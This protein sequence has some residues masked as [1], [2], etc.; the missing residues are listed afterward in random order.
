M[1]ASA[2]GPGELDAN[3]KI[4]KIGGGE[5]VIPSSG[6]YGYGGKAKIDKGV[7]YVLYNGKDMKTHGEH[8]TDLFQF[9]YKLKP[10]IRYKLN[11]PIYDFEIDWRTK[12]LYGLRM[13][14]S[15]SQLVIFQL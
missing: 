14:G 10:T 9:T 4:Q 5:R 2:I 8:V 7:I 13:E 11:I 12:R 1:I 15:T 6:R 3:Y